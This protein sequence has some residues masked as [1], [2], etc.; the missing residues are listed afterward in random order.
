MHKN[1]DL[2]KIIRGILLLFSVTA[3]LILFLIVMFLFKEGLP[4]FQH[5]SVID[6]LFGDKWI[7][8]ESLYGAFPFIIST[9]LVTFGAL[10]IAVPLGVSCA[11]FLAEIAPGWIRDLVRPAIELLAGIP[12]I[13]YGLFALVVIVDLIKISFNLATGETILAGSVILAVMI[14]PI[15]I[16]ISQ[17]SIDAVPRTYREGSYAMGATDWQTISR[18]VVPAARAGIIAGIILGCGR[19]IGETMAVALVIGNAEKLPLSLLDSG[20]TLTTA[21]LLE[22]GEAVIGGVHYNALFCLGIIPFIIV[23]FFS[24][25]SSRLI[26]KRVSRFE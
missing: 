13:I 20:E 12:S 10:M 25:I 6:F 21:I 7:P 19:A 1:F 23:L 16:S 9:L 22:M 24:V 4:L 2:E 5:I 18:V 14:L 17:D 26:S 15:I 3:V 11:V 8:S